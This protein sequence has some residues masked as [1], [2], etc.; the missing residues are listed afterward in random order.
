MSDDLIR[1]KDAIELI[2]TLYPSKPFMQMNRKHWEEKYKPYI[3]CEKALDRL[4]SAQA[5]IT[6]EMVKEYCRE[7]CLCIVD[8]ALL[9][10]VN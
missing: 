8:S 4:P 3:E 2:R 9:R 5:E 1:R 6:E 10:E 7:R